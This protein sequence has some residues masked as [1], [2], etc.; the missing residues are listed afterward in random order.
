MRKN[1][2]RYLLNHP[3]FI[4]LKWEARRLRTLFHADEFRLWREL[5]DS[6]PLVTIRKKYP[7]F[8]YKYLGTYIGKGF[9]RSTKLAILRYH[10][11]FIK[12][13]IGVHFFKALDTSLVLWSHELDD[14]I[15]TISLSH[16]PIVDFESELS[17]S[18]TLDGSVLQVLGFVIAPGSV[19]GTPS[20]ATLLLSQVQGIKDAGLLKDVT[21]MLKDITPAVV[22]VNAA[23]GLAAALGIA[24]AAGVSTEQQVSGPHIYFK[25][26]EFWRVLGGKETAGG[27][28]QVPIPTPERPINQISSNHRSK[29]LRKRHFKQSVREA[30]G[31]K[32][33]VFLGL[34]CTGN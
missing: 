5:A 6:L 13:R 12:Y 9:S 28:F 24:Q 22:L 2:E 31:K 19:L 33:G 25:Y 7:Y 8:L 27:I 32:V 29:T 34:G 17:L 14:G 23:Y 26:S 10:Y 16:P 18:F 21:R 20:G 4:F 1:I 3:Y 15:L 11:G 30:V